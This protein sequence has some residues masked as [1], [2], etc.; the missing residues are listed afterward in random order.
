VPDV[1]LIPTAGEFENNKV[2]LMYNE[3]KKDN[4]ENPPSYPEIG[5]LNNSGTKINDIYELQEAR[6]E[7]WKWFEEN[8]NATKAM[9]IVEN[10]AGTNGRI[11]WIDFRL[12]ISEDGSTIHLHFTPSENY[13]IGDLA[14]NLVK[15]GHK[16]GLR[17]I[18]TMKSGPSINVLAVFEK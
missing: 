18:G 7:Y 15:R 2:I 12:P 3:M 11:R 1:K 9:K 10:A 5:K 8:Y 4:G 17:I 13:V 14:Y 6:K 16:H